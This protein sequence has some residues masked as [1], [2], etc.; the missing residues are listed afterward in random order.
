MN[1]SST[2]LYA[3]TLGREW[4]LSL[5]ELF[6]V[7]GADAY[8]IHT[9][10]IAIFQI[11]GYSDEQLAKKFLTIGGSIRIIKILGETDTKRFPTD[12]IAHIQ[13]QWEAKWGKLTFAL[14]SY[15]IDF[16]VSNIGLRIKK[17]LQER[18]FS[19]RLVN[20]ENRNIVSAVFKREKLG[21]SQT[22]YNLIQTPVGEEL[23]V[24][25]ACQ[26][27]DAYANRDTG[28]SRDMI[29]GMMP[30]KL[31]QMMINLAGPSISAESRQKLSAIY[32]PF[33]GLGTTLIEAA[34]MGITEVYGSDISA[35]MVRATTDS[36][37]EFIKTEK[38][39]QE[40]IRAV[41]G[42]PNK[43]FSD[44]QSAI[45]QLDA[46]KVKDAPEKLGTIDFHRL[47]L[48]I[49]SEGF[50]G[51]I[52]SPRDI[53]LEKVQA[54]RKK[55]ASMYSD[56]F[57]WLADANF[58]GSIVMSF[59][60]WNI[61]GTYSYFGEIYEVIEKNG[62]EV[63]SLLPWEMKLNT[64]KWSLLYR[65]ENQTVGREIVKIVKKSR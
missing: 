28:K 2:N 43:D 25:I 18:G 56:F 54:E 62:F 65:R 33:C 36:L 27:I 13:S 7:F 29:V 16:P 48:A 34:N 15:G 45:I 47:N 14:G 5:A 57:R 44:F 20:I 8:R 11:H 35:D 61:H 41:W 64:A 38:M 51:E 58:R 3:F 22:E 24:T 53:G 55:L 31:V 37:D 49:V 63:V 42:T 1:N 4:K 46:R 12:V 40:R 10:T 23:G 60:F 17:T 19:A 21:K 6:A 52:M 9:E 26:D 39:W 30:P 32:D 59:P 50:L